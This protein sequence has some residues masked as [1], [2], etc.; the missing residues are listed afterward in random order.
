MITEYEL[1]GLSAPKKFTCYHKGLLFW[2]DTNMSDLKYKE[3]FNWAKHTDD[4]WKKPGWMAVI[5]HDGYFEDGT[6]IK[7]I[8]IEIKDLR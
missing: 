4:F 8:V 5:E 3:L 6:P 2:A 1:R 7:P